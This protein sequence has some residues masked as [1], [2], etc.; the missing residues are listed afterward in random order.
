MPTAERIEGKTKRIDPRTTRTRQLLFDAFRSMLAEKSFEE[1][2]VQDIAERA[3]VNRATFYAHFADKYALGDTLMREGFTRIL[4][5]RLSDGAA[6]PYDYL[7]SLFLAITDHWTE[8]HGQC[9]PSYRMFESLVESQIKGLLFENIR[10]WMEEHS[11]AGSRQDREMI[12]TIVSASLYGA[13]MQ[14]TQ[15]RRTE[16]AEGFAKKAVPVVAASL[17]ALR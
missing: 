12:A 16:S 6:A 8:L 2:T 15:I 4:Q 13:A 5:K 7:H 3:T 10:S 1:I 11:N 9:R 14:W 17:Q